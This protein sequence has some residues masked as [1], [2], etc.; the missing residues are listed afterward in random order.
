MDS[1]LVLKDE[2]LLRVEA[3]P[4][5]DLDGSLRARLAVDAESHVGVSATPDD[6]ANPV[7]VQ[8]HPEAQAG[9][10]RLHRH[11]SADEE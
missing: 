2:C 3:V 6:L 11:A 5:N 8:S 10:F 4:R 9:Y 1:D 7:D